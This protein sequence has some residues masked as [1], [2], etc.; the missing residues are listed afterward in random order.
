LHYLFVVS[1]IFQDSDKSRSTS[2]PTTAF[3]I[4]ILVSNCTGRWIYY[5]T[6]IMHLILS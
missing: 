1:I 4:F 2:M 6:D 3:Q 5:S